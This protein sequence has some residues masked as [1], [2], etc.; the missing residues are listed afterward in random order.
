MRLL[1]TYPFVNIRSS[2]QAR[3]KRSLGGSLAMLL[4]HEREY[5]RAITEAYRNE[6]PELRRQVLVRRRRLRA[7]QRHARG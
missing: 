1:Y 5:I 2:E 7:S 3:A 4:F 6:E